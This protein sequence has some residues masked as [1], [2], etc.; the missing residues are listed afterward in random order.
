MAIDYRDL[1]MK[2]IAHVG[3]CEGVTFLPVREPNGEG[4]G[5]LS[6]VAFTVEEA[7]ALDELG[8]ESKKFDG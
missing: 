1:L 5:N 8:E 6:H 4:W 3:R 7:A 2:Y